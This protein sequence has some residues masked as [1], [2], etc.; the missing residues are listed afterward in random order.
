MTD[1]WTCNP[2]KTHQLAFCYVAFSKALGACVNCV[3]VRT[4]PSKAGISFP[5]CAPVSPSLLI[6]PLCARPGHLYQAVRPTSKEKVSAVDGYAILVIH[7]MPG[8]LVGQGAEFSR[9]SCVL[10]ELTVRQP[11]RICIS[12]SFSKTPPP[13]APAFPSIGMLGLVPGLTQTHT[14]PEISAP[15]PFPWTYPS[16]STEKLPSL[17]MTLD[18]FSP[19]AHSSP[20]AGREGRGAGVGCCCFCSVI[21]SLQSSSICIQYIKHNQSLAY[22]IWWRLNTSV[23]SLDPTERIF[24]PGTKIEIWDWF[25][26][27]LWI[28]NQPWATKTLS[29]S[30]YHYPPPPVAK[31]PTRVIR[32]SKALPR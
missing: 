12:F 15:P 29:Y 7:V 21:I 27:Q 8:G 28:C 11:K 19:L 18:H 24:V 4:K 26:L 14:G 10:V 30:R 13:P 1:W 20:R 22:F 9:S 32:Y 23:L 6:F 3:L 5:H 16:G 17:R 2:F 25:L 31:C